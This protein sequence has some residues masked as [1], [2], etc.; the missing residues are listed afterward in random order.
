MTQIPTKPRADFIA[1]ALVR[2]GLRAPNQRQFGLNDPE[3]RELFRPEPSML[4]NF[5]RH[6]HNPVV[7]DEWGARHSQPRSRGRT[8]IT[9]SR[10]PG[11]DPGSTC[12]TSPEPKSSAPPP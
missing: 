12:S 6:E 10:H 9:L 2:A 5:P 11:L 1:E 4:P 3:A 8:G 7:R